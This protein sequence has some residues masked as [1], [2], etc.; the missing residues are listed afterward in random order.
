MTY[1]K[2]RLGTAGIYWLF[3]RQVLAAVSETA[4]II[5]LRFRVQ[6]SNFKIIMIIRRGG[7]SSAHLKHTGRTPRFR[8]IHFNMDFRAHGNCV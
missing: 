6:T 2:T 1:R 4:R 7:E 3:A 5:T 8:S